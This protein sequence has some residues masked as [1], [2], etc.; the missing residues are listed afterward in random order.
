MQKKYH[1][2]DD[3]K[4]EV[5]LRIVSSRYKDFKSRLRGFFIY[6]TRKPTSKMAEISNP[7]LIYKQIT[8]EDWIEFEKQA[9][10]LKFKVKIHSFLIKA[11]NNY[12]ATFFFQC[13]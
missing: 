5:V 10:D 12:S 9:N 3:T 11:I 13:T 7:L 2:K 1:I 8:K 6:K 4:E